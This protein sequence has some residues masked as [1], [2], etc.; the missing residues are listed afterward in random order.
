M[1]KGVL[2]KN[3]MIKEVLNKNE[4]IKGVLTKNEMIK[5]VLTINGR[6]N[7]QFSNRMWF[8]PLSKFRVLPNR[9]DAIEPTGYRNIENR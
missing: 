1:I 5:G 6:G 9:M 2:T 4:M 7:I 8:I 3:E